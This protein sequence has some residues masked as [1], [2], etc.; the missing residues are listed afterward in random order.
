MSYGGRAN[1]VF[2][3]NE[4]MNQLIYSFDSISY[5]AY[6]A[7][8]SARTIL[9]H[10]RDRSLYLDALNIRRE[11]ISGVNDQPFCATVEGF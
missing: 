6:D 4:S 9:K 8:A 2:V 3:Y 11:L 7:N 5:F 1:R 10:I